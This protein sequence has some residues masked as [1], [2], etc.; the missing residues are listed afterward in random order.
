MIQVQPVF[1][2]RFFKTYVPFFNLPRTISKIEIYI[3]SNISVVDRYYLQYISEIKHSPSQS[4]FLFIQPRPVGLVRNIILEKNTVKLAKNVIMHSL[5]DS[6]L[7]YILH[8]I[9]VMFCRNAQ[10]ILC[11]RILKFVKQYTRHTD[12]LGNT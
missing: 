1:L 12:L 9:K 2:L 7:L 10:F 6:R 5:L 8:G 11:N 4:P 3:S